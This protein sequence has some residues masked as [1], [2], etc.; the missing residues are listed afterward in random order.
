[1]SEAEPL[2]RTEWRDSFRI[3]ADHPALRGHFP[4]L[5]VVPGV[6]LVTTALDAAE[7]RLGSALAIDGI[8]QVKFLRPVRPDESVDVTFTLTATH[9]SLKFRCVEREVANGTLSLRRANIQ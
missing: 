4:G 2:A 9:L 3:S 5:P 1:M 8:P 7:R 6:L